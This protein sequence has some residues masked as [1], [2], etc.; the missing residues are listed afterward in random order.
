MIAYFFTCIHFISS[1]FLPGS[2]RTQVISHNFG[3]FSSSGCRP[4]ELYWSGSLQCPSVHLSVCKHVCWQTVIFFLV[5][6]Q[7]DIEGNILTSL[8]K[9]S[10]QWSWRRCNNNKMFTDRW[11]N[12]YR[13]DRSQKSSSGLFPEELMIREH[14]IRENM[15]RYHNTLYIQLPGELYADGSDMWIYR[16]AYSSLS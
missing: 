9:K 11:T 8:K 13:R 7:F 4:E 6:A 10:S 15:W 16:Y 2:F 3:H 12:G 5:L 14:M 1:H